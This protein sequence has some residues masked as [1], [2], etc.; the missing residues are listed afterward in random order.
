MHARLKTD[1]EFQKGGNV[2]KL[3]K[4][5]KDEITFEIAKVDGEELI[6]L[7]I[8]QIKKQF[9]DR[10]IAFTSGT[11]TQVSNLRDQIE[12]LESQLDFQ[13]RRLKAIKENQFTCTRRGEIVFM[14]ADLN[15]GL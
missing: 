15:E 10:L 11:M 4:S 6:H 7:S 13:L 8:E 5:S 14:E 12:R 1:H 3:V 2:T 9:G